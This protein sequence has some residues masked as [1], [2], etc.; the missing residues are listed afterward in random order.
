MSTPTIS[1]SEASHRLL[2][3]L[4]EQTGQTER[5]VLDKALDAYWRKLFFEQLN[6]GYAEMQADPEAWAEHLAELREWD[7]TLMDGLDPD[8][9]WT[10]DGRCLNPPDVEES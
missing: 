9:R 6:A 7:A 3:E 4:A 1:I 8:E 10:E 5:E 2:Q